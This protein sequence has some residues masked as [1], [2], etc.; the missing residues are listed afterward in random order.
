MYRKQVTTH[1]CI[2][3]IITHTTIMIQKHHSAGITLSTH[4]HKCN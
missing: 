4:I 2:D 3:I 1:K